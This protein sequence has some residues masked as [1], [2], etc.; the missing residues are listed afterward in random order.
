[1]LTPSIGF[2]V[3]P[4]TCTGCGMPAASRIVGSTSITWW[5]CQRMPPLSL[6]FAGEEVGVPCLVAQK[7]AGIFLVHLNGGAGRPLRERNAL[8]RLPHGSGFTLATPAGAIAIL[9]QDFTDRG[10]LR[11]H[12]H[13]IA[14]EAGRHWGEHSDADRVVVATSEQRRAR[15]RAQRRGMEVGVTQAR[16]SNL[17][18]R[19]GRDDAAEGRVRAVAGVVEQDQ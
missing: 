5:N 8:A 13:V 3:T 14:G 6:I 4:F 15:G 11:S 10:N 17:V 1:M 12:G 2:W 16:A 7:Y 9:T 19:G 18:E